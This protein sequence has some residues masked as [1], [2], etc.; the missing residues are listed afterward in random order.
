MYSK[1]FYLTSADPDHVLGVRKVTLAGNV[2]CFGERDK[3]F[4]ATLEPPIDGKLFDQEGPITEVILSQ[5]HVGEPLI[6]PI[7]WP[8]DVYIS[9]SLSRMPLGTPQI[10]DEDFKMVRWGL[11]FNTSE[12][13]ENRLAGYSPNKRGVWPRIDG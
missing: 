13:A 11:L 1:E 8:V 5:R 9:V 10:A 7:K 2:N 4:W 6:N 12:D 3:Y